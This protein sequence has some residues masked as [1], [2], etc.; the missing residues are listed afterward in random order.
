MADPK[1]QQLKGHTSVFDQDGQAWLN[2]EK[3]HINKESLS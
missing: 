2:I 1:N 3:K